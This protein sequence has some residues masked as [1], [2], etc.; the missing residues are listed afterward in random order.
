[1]DRKQGKHHH[2]Q[3]SFLQNTNHSPPHAKPPRVWTNSDTYKE[4]MAYARIEGTVLVVFVRDSPV[5][6]E[7]HRLFE[8]YTRTNGLCL[9]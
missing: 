9:Q 6:T 5:G 1:M 4:L 8:D 2:N 7:K 3:R